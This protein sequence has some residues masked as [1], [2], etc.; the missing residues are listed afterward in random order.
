MKISL[1]TFLDKYIVATSHEEAKD[2]FVDLVVEILGEE[3]TD[4]QM[5][6]LE[7]ICNTD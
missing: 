6:R 3:Q 4:E 1:Q 7:A 2:D 5:E